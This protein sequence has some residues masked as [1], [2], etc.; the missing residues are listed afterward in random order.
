MPFRPNV[1]LQQVSNVFLLLLAPLCVECFC[2]IS[3]LLSA[4]KCTYS[5]LVAL[6]TPTPAL[7]QMIVQLPEEKSNNDNSNNSNIWCRHKSSGT[8]ASSSSCSSQPKALP[9]LWPHS[10][11][12]LSLGNAKLVFLLPFCCWFAWRQSHSSTHTRTQNCAQIKQPIPSNVLKGYNNANGT[13]CD[14]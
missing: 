5:G 3:A 10:G 2:S 4:W 12:T 7:S 11:S 8:K 9:S 6:P 1:I 14:C 13:I